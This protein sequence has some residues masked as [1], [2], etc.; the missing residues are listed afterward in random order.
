MSRTKFASC[1]ALLYKPSGNAFLTRLSENWWSH[2]Q[3][4]HS[5]FFSTKPSLIQGRSGLQRTLHRGS[6]STKSTHLYVSLYFC[7]CPE[8]A[9]TG[10]I[11]A[12]LCDNT[13]IE[14]DIDTVVALSQNLPILKPYWYCKI[15]VLNFDIDVG[16]AKTDF[17]LSILVL[18]LQKPSNQCCYWYWYCM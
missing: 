4:F 15:W 9:S 10:V 16:I 11:Q 3:V 2:L 7:G 17:L 12:G 1:I 14:G 8:I 18:I 5:K 13:V 6:K